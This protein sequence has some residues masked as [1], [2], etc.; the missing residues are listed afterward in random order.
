[1]IRNDEWITIKIDYYTDLETG[2]KMY[3]FEEMEAQFVEHMVELR[4]DMDE[5]IDA[6]NDKQ[7][8]YAM[9]SMTND[10]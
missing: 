1:M 5:Q 2:I 10:E 4:N 7:L 6:W 9:D 3:D 8:D